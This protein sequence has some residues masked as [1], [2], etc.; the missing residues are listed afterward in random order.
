MTPQA[1]RCVITRAVYALAFSAAACAQ[2]V[3]TVWSCDRVDSA[4]LGAGVEWRRLNCSSPSIP[5]F[6]PAGPVI[7]NLV[8]ADLRTPGLRLA[9]L[10]SS[11]NVS[12]LTQIAAAAPTAVAGINGG[13]F[14]RVDSATFFDGVCLLKSRNDALLPPNASNPNA[15]IGDGTTVADGKLL[16][17]NCNCL[18]YSRPAVLTID[19]PASRVDVVTRGAPPPA[20]LTKDAIAAGPRVVDTNA[21]GTFIAIPSDDGA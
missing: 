18:G 14:W 8:V 9:P 3:V 6:G 13:Y 16:S 17:S 11:T 7:V 4:D 1:R 15:G 12:T 5:V 19:G 2:N 20:G 21:S 10:T